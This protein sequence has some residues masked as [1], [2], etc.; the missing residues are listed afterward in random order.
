MDETPIKIGK[1]NKYLNIPYW[2]RFRPSLNGINFF[3]L[4][5][6]FLS[7]Y[8]VPWKANFFLIKTILF[9]VGKQVVFPKLSKDSSDSFYMI[10]AGVLSVNCDIIK[11]ENNKNIK[12][13]YWN[14]VN[15]AI[16]AGRGIGKTKKYDLIFKIAVPRSESCIL[17]VTIP[18]SHL[19]I[20]VCQ[21]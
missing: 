21:V 1:P 3:F 10:L 12:F 5:I 2:L 16:K 14:F 18:S 4:Y 13:F 17:L 6:D 9:Q 15:I 8:D 20:C 11:V 19:M 7:R